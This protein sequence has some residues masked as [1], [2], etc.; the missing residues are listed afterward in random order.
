M[1]KQKISSRVL[2]ARGLAIYELEK[3]FDY[4]RTIDPDL[5]SSQAIVLAASVLAEL[6]SLFQQNP[7]L[8]DRIKDRAN[9]KFEQR[10]ID[11]QKTNL[12][13]LS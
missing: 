13:K 12:P 11:Y 4:I 7:E 1:T 3:F 10:I 6:P 8:V 5:E 9:I 2:R